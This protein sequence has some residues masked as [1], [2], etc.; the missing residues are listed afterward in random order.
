MTDEPEI[1]SF[2]VGDRVSKRLEG[3]S[4]EEWYERVKRE[5]RKAPED[6]HQNA[7]G[8]GPDGDD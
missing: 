7:G 5:T 6:P 8:L 4:T 1:T 2:S 3:E